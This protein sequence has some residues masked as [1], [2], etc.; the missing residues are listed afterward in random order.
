MKRERGFTLIELLIAIGIIAILAGLLFVVLPAVR[1]RARIAHCVNSLKQVGAALLMYAQDYDGFAP[2]Y[3]N[4]V[5]VDINRRYFPNYN[6]PALFEGAYMPYTKDKQI[7]Y[8]PSDPYAGKSTLDVPK[9]P[10][11]ETWRGYMWNNIDHKATSYFIEGACATR[12][13]APVRVDNPPNY[14]Q[15]RIAD[16]IPMP[17]QIPEKW[18]EPLAYAQDFTNGTSR[19]P[20]G[21]VLSFNGS[22]KVKR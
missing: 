14:L 5:G 19:R 6:D 18:L 8:C 15:K 2:P 16:K 21:I 7:W 13:L 12:V 9:G 22:V 17:P 10:E 4:S 3:A 11:P 1:E 20:F